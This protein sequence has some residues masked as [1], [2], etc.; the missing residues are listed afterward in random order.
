MA[1]REVTM[2]EVK[3]VLRL[4]KSGMPK[5]RIAAQLGFDVKT[6]RRYIKAARQCGL[7]CEGSLE[8]LDDALVASVVGHI[9]PVL[10]RPHGD[11]WGVCES[12]RVFVRQ[13]LT[14]G[15]RLTKI[16]KLLRR[17]GI[18]VSYPTLRRFAIGE[19][20][21]GQQAA[22]IPVAD[23][24][25]GEELQCD[26][27]WMTHLE[28][29]LF[30]RRRRFRVWI[31][32]AVRSRHRF[33]YPVFAETT[34]TAIEACEMGWE[35]FGG[36]FKALIVDNTK[37]IVH[38]ADPLGPRINATFLEYAQ[39]RG[40]VV[41]TTRVRSPKDKARVERSVSTVRDDCFA[42]ER[43]YDL[44]QARAHARRWCLTEYGM[45]RHSTTLRVPLEQFQAEEHPAL[46]PAPTE[47]YDTPLW[48]EPKVARDQHAQVAKALYS[49]P[50]RWR[51]KI[52][53]ARADR[54]TVRFYD[55]TVLVKTHPRMAPGKRSTDPNDFPP[56]KAAYALRDVA[57]LARQAASHGDS[58]GR[59]AARLLE[60]ELPWTRMRQVY[61]LL[62]LARRFGDERLDAACRTALEADMIDVRR[63]GRLIE[64]AL[65]ATST[66]TARVIPLA[67]YLRPASQFRL[68]LPSQRTD[69]EDR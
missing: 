60:G 58:V 3:E 28:P 9:K 59:F 13:K 2:I 18:E 5:K 25:P 57:F 24:E 69:G 10:G 65:P 15:I 20:G 40:F 1:H 8:A 14:E 39:H 29:D 52:L 63:L 53:R 46:R 44:D 54:S 48:C 61:A 41:D 16:A 55:G 23:C 45:R 36:I 42:G 17:Q 34:Q 6:V 64:L 68:P 56:H 26:T 19:L 66:A 50:S 12:Q 33:V 51:A 30:G 32:T 27:G 21:F 35:F 49:L 43:L 22:T 4:W 47:P 11:V 7:E 67:R 62:G 37:A 31:F 38:K